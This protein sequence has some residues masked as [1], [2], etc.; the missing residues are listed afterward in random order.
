MPDKRNVGY[1]EGELILAFFKSF[2]IL[3]ALEFWQ[4]SGIEPFVGVHGGSSV[5]CIVAYTIK[6]D[7]FLSIM[8]TWLP[9]GPPKTFALLYVDFG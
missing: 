4:V 9:I 1:V 5:I 8:S 3:L 6:V 2:K 7:H